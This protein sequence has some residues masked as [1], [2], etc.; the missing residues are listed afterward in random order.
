[1]KY[2]DKIKLFKACIDAEIALSIIKAH[3]LIDEYQKF[4]YAI[5]TETNKKMCF[6]PS[7]DK[8]INMRGFC[9]QKCHDLF[10]DEK[11]KVI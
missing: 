7:C 4:K 5:A 9:S 1:M 8:K 2:D 6:G 11:H 3:K 10:Y